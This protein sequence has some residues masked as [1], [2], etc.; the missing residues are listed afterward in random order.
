M[1]KTAIRK[2]LLSLLLAM[3]CA[4]G[5]VA[6]SACSQ[7]SSND[8][9]SLKQNV[10]ASLDA[11]IDKDTVSSLFRSIDGVS[12]LE[13]YG[14]D[15][16]ALSETIVSCFSYEIE[17]VSIDGDNATVTVKMSY[18]DYE[19]DELATLVTK[20]VDEANISEM[21]EIDDIVAAYQAVISEALGDESLP[22]ASQ[23]FEIPCV[24][25]NGSWVIKDKNALME[26]A[27]ALL[28][29]ASSTDSS[30]SSASDDSESSSAK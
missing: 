17:N 9:E 3:A 24:K 2:R 27:Q 26:Q 10:S 8:E 11:L 5:L 18:P 20:K 22:R 15:V 16:D 28:S 14:F 6:L 1:Q 12:L 30:S 21:T 25:E 7:D 29:V 23:E 19:S 4:F 13:G